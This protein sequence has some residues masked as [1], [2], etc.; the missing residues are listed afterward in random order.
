M[1][2]RSSGDVCSWRPPR[3]LEERG[4]A[5]GSAGKLTAEQGPAAGGRSRAD[6]EGD[7]PGLTRDL[8]QVVDDAQI[9]GRGGRTAHAFLDALFVRLGVLG[10]QLLESSALGLDVAG[11]H[12]AARQ[13]QVAGALEEP[14]GA[15]EER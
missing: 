11:Q 6:A 12:P 13:C 15:L 14:D 7:E 8:A 2:R 1:P 9:R 10:D 5:K 3:P 4:R